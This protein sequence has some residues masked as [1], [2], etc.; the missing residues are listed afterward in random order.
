MGH[1]VSTQKQIVDII[2]SELKDY[3]KALSYDEKIIFDNIIGDVYSHI[4]SISNAGSI[5][6]WAF[7]LLSIILEQK[8]EIIRIKNMVEQNERIHN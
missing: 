3:R 1:T 4:G 2:I 8:K 7:F 5:H 6:T